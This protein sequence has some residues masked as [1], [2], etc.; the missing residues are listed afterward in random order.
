[1]A[2]GHALAM[3]KKTRAMNTN[4]AMR[5]RRVQVADIPQIIALDAQVTKLAKA[6]YWNDVF[7]RYGKR[8]PHERFFLVA[9]LPGEGVRPCVVGFIIGEIR[10]WEFG[11]ATDSRVLSATNKPVKPPMCIVTM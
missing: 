1:M 7:S 6:D 8:R 5:V 3:A 10:A 9:E 4:T 2:E 11:S